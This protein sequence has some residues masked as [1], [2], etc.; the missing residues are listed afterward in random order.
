MKKQPSEN[1]ARLVIGCWF[2]TSVIASAFPG[3][4]IYNLDNEALIGT[5]TVIIFTGLPFMAALLQNKEEDFHWDRLIILKNIINLPAVIVFTVPTAAAIF[6][7][8]TLEQVVWFAST[9]PLLP[10]S[11]LLG[12]F[13]WGM[14]KYI[15]ALW[16]IYAWLTD[17]GRGNSELTY[18]A[19][20]RLKLLEEDMSE[21]KRSRIWDSRTWRKLTNQPA[22]EQ[23]A[24][25]DLFVQNI[26]G[27]QDKNI[28]ARV[29][30]VL[31]S[32]LDALNLSN[33]N[34]YKS[35]FALA[36]LTELSKKKDRIW[37]LESQVEQLRH[38]LAEISL[39]AKTPSHHYWLSHSFFIECEEALTS[40]PSEKE[41]LKFMQKIATL[42][43]RI[44]DKKNYD[45]VA[46]QGFCAKWKITVEKLEDAENGPYVAVWLWAY[47]EWLER[48]VG[49]EKIIES[50]N[51]NL[52]ITKFT[53]KLMP[54]LHLGCWLNFL[55]LHN[56]TQF[57]FLKDDR[58]VVREKII[59][60]IADWESP[61]YIWTADVIWLDENDS[62]DEQFNLQY[63]QAIK[64]AASIYLYSKFAPKKTDMQKIDEY[65][66]VTEGLIQ[67]CQKDEGQNLN[68]KKLNALAELFAELRNLLREPTSDPTDKS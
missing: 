40:L 42:F 19:E 66:S 16:K 7:W 23:E 63:K 32:N 43:F 28:K 25:F 61:K 27:L 56:L 68:L 31:N 30:N 48:T 34:I 29:I 6:L 39:I 52:E 9:S 17:V 11:M 5:A 13:V 65:I 33:N 2:A 50:F 12:I 67:E 55:N 4:G 44:L 18:R 24:I 51:N 62:D 26:R 20:Q 45:E 37:F 15:Y 21:Q 35:L 54:G 1:K 64:A 36:F 58:K 53:K 14:S 10:R 47:I 60:F 8:G 38:G 41:R 57:Y 59:Y 49:L 46:W 3:F 22:A